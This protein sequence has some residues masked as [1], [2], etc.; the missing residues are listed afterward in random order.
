[1]LI[2]VIK[3]SGIREYWENSNTV[4]LKDDNL[5]QLESD[6]IIQW[7]NPVDS[8][9][10][11]GCGDGV[12]S[13]LYAK[14]ASHLIGVDYSEEMIKKAKQRLKGSD[15][16]NVEFRTVSVSQL[17]SMAEKFDV[18]ITQRCL[19]N[20]TSFEDQQSAIISLHNLIKPKGLY[21]MLECFEQGLVFL[22]EL[23]KNL[24]LE[25]L[26]MPWHNRFFDLNELMAVLKSRFIIKSIT[27]FSLYY[28]ITR[29][30]NELLGLDTSDP[31][32]KQIDTAAKRMEKCIRLESLNGIGSQKLLVLQKI[33]KFLRL[34]FDNEI[35]PFC[36]DVTAFVESYPCGQQRMPFGKC[37]WSRMCTCRCGSNLETGRNH[38]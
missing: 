30:L 27:D 12:N 2:M 36:T 6:A 17:A 14:S 20:L 9:L 16:C 13:I 4:S 18:V 22:N 21:L 31:M 34:D 23:R 37:I 25:P 11:V 8:V 32:S 7:I 1:M 3:K 38:R 26:P 10:D 15:L 5:R 24:G 33:N 35:I 28:L 19:I 29:L